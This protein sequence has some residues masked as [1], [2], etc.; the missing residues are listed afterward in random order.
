MNL[1]SNLDERTGPN[2]AESSLWGACVISSTASEREHVVGADTRGPDGFCPNYPSEPL[3]SLCEECSDNTEGVRSVQAVGGTWNS[4]RHCPGQSAVPVGRGLGLHRFI[5]IAPNSSE[6]IAQGAGSTLPS[7]PEVLTLSPGS[8]V[9]GGR[10]GGAGG[11]G[12][13][14]KGNEVNCDRE[15][16]SPGGMA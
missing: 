9:P 6:A 7:T 5:S 15:G 16:K 14:W 2:K 1:Q 12:G 8:P 10:R 13:G 3:N 11:T 4:K